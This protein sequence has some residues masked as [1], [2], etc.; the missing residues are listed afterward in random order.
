[1]KKRNITFIT[2]FIAVAVIVSVSLLYGKLL[3]DDT[4]YSTFFVSAPDDDSRT[5]IAE[6]SELGYGDE[7]G[8]WAVLQLSP[9]YS[10]GVRF[11]NVSLPKHAEIIEAHIRLL[12][13][14]TPISNSVNCFIYG[15]D[16]NHSHNFS[17]QGV[18]QR[19]GR[20][21]TTNSVEWNTTVPYYECVQTP[22]IKTIV[23]E[24]IN[25]ETWEQ[26]NG[27]SILFITKGLRGYS[28]AFQNFE[29]GYPPALCVQWRPAREE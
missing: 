16:S 14:S 8:E 7:D 21:F 9:S 3:P 19:C 25:N 22:N 2:V 27:L 10:F 1:M 28:A 18:L 11:G 29:S 20:T 23:Q 4:N 5:F 6:N 13:I 12:S 24:I 15:D 17:V 26:G